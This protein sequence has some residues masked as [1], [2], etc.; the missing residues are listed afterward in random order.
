MGGVSWDRGG[1]E[2]TGEYTFFYESKIIIMN[3]V[4]P[5][6]NKR[7]ISAIKMIDFVSN[8]MPCVLLRGLL[9]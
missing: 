6:P 4:L 8:R 1:T 3:W 5:P 7:I 2:A 9:V